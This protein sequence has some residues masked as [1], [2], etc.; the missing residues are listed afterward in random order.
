[1]KHYP[2][3]SLETLAKRI[4]LANGAF[5]QAPL[6]LALIDRWVAGAE[7]YSLTCCDG[8]VNKLRQ[9]TERLPDAVV[10]DLDS[11][12][13]E[14]R[15]LLK[16]RTH[17]SPDQETNDLTKTMRYL[18]ASY[19][20]SAITL[21]GASG[22]REDHLLA[23]LVLLPT[24]APLV[25]ELVMLTD[26]GYFLLITEPS[27]VAVEPGQQLSVFD[28]YR[29]PLTFRG[30]RWPLEAYTLPELS[31]GSLNCAIAPEVYL[32]AERP[33]LLYVANL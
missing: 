25:E 23:N 29:Q 12:A 3:Y 1:M 16:D 17:H 14:L 24:Y 31:S 9:Y 22:G 8:G 18:H 27:L 21:L 11:A 15:Q 32:E 4:V 20:P 28:F 10:G 33:L 30:V 6:P 2:R 26:E 19:G 5:P 7:G 13:P